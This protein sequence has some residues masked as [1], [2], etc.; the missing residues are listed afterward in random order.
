MMLTRSGPHAANQLLHNQL[1][2]TLPTRPRKQ[3]HDAADL[4]RLEFAHVLCEP[5]QPVEH[6]YFPLR[7]FISLIATLDDDARIEVGMVGREGMFGVNWMLGV[8]Q[9]G[10]QAVV[11]GA[12]QALRISASVFERHLENHPESRQR[13]QR[14]AAA[15]IAQLTRTAVCNSFHHIEQRLARWLLMCLDRSDDDTIMLTQRF[16]AYMLGVRRVGITQAASTL[17]EK[18][19]INY[20]RGKISLRDRAGME[21]VACGCYQADLDTYARLL[22]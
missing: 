1:L 7:G 21:A 2:Q 3:L 10:V 22:G 15:Q 19:L 6:V 9:S 18:Q 16:L 8:E 20:A 12:G 14:Y 13:M 17:Q 5:G 11:Q 4:V